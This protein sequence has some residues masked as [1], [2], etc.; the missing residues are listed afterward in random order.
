MKRI[1]LD[2]E[3]T[4]LQQ[5]TSL[6][7]LALVAE[8]GE[9]FYAE[10]TDYNNDQITVWLKEYVLSQLFIKDN[11]SANLNNIQIK[12]NKEVIKS[13]LINWFQQFPKQKN[14]IQIWADC[15]AW[16]WVLFCELFGGAFNIPQNIHY[17][18]MDLAT[19]L[20]SKNI[21][22]DTERIKLLPDDYKDKDNLKQHN[23]LFDAR[24][25]LAV[26]NALN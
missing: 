23:A 24:V 4:G 9:E 3:F 11:K 18:T 2:T 25:E 8:S 15:Y 7:S 6:V 5:N 14:S 22:V 20:F 17:M 19:Y 21:A 13:A 26:F 16:D 12:G 10:F 1:F